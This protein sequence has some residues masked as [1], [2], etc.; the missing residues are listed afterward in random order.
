MH[1][2][3]KN[4]NWLT[5]QYLFF[6]TP[7]EIPNA[8]SSIIAASSKFTIGGTKAEINVIKVFRVAIFYYRQVFIVF[9]DT[10]R[11]NIDIG[12]KLMSKVCDCVYVRGRG[13]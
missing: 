6:L 9:I 13:K 7:Q 2:I 1:S 10:N 12:P 4:K 3:N 5:S 8:Q 11:F